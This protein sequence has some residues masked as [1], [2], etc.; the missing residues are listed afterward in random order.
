VIDPRR[1]DLV[2]SPHV[3][4]DYHLPLRPGTNVA[5]LSAL[6]HV[7]VTEGLVNEAFVRERCDWDE[8][9]HWAEFVS[10]ERNSPEFLEPVTGVPADLVR[11]RRG[12]MPRAAMARSIMAWA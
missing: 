7:I 12:S 10:Q 6:A 2:R 4:A 8:F 3:E 9:Q 11:G 5:V 1:T